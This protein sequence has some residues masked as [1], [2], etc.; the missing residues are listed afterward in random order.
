MAK[1]LCTIIVQRSNW[2]YQAH[3][4]RQKYG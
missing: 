4:R 3:C 1:E 2:R